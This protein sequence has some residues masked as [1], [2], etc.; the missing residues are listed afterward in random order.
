MKLHHV[1]I[2]CE[3]I[4]ATIEELKNTFNITE[5]NRNHI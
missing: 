5:I 3:D 1:G 4:S 2:A